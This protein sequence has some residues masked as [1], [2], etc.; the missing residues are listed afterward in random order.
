MYL[1]TFMLNILYLLCWDNTS[2]RKRRRKH[3][4]QAE[5]TATQVCT[6]WHSCWIFFI[7]LLCWDNCQE[8][9]KRRS[10]LTTK[11]NEKQC[12]RRR[13]TDP[14]SPEQWFFVT[15]KHCTSPERKYYYNSV[16]TRRRRERTFH[17]CYL[18]HSNCVVLIRG[19]GPVSGEV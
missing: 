7:Y 18:T 8:R 3:D 6:S 10:T 19:T 9:R 12:F 14:T 16:G 4:H 13:N 17:K 11:P 5:G 2:R 15:L 1:M